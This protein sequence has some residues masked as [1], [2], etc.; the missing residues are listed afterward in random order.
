MPLEGRQEQGI[1]Y[2]SV[3][4]QYTGSDIGPLKIRDTESLFTLT[5]VDGSFPTQVYTLPGI[6]YEILKT[7]PD[8]LLKA[9]LASGSPFTD[10]R[11][12]IGPLDFQLQPTPLL[13]DF[14]L[15]ILQAIGDTARVRW[16]GT[17][18]SVYDTGGTTIVAVPGQTSLFPSFD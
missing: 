17:L 6:P 11:A 3:I 15:I 18:W 9:T 8:R 5:N 12:F 16:T 1:T 4:T 13:A 10:K 14:R 7:P 2:P